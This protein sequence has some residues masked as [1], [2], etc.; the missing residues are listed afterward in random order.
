MSV[1]LASLTWS[2]FAGFCLHVDIPTKDNRAEKFN[3]LLNLF[4]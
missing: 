3:S 4:P 1:V 2:I